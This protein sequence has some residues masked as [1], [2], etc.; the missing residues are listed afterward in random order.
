MHRDLLAQHAPGWYM[1]SVSGNISADVCTTIQPLGLTTCAHA[2]HAQAVRQEMWHRQAIWER[3]GGRSK[4]DKPAAA[5]H[6]TSSWAGKHGH[7]GLGKASSWLCC[8]AQ[9]LHMLAHMLAHGIMAN[10]LGLRMC[11]VS[12]VAL[13][14]ESFIVGHTRTTNAPHVFLCRN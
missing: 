11:S 2:L 7:C 10:L 9:A 5:R 1:A 13:T 3:C 4:V 14:R 12:H 8:R 6:E